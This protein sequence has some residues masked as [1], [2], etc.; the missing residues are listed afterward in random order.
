MAETEQIIDGA[1]A[2]GEVEV[3]LYEHFYEPDVEA[4]RAFYAAIAA[5]DLKGQP[6]WPMIVAP[7][8]CGKT[9]LINPLK[10]MPN[11][12]LIDSITPNTLISGRAPE[13]GKQR[14]KEG[15]L[16]RIGSNGMIFI[17]D[18]STLLEG[19]REK[20]DQVFAQLR[21]VYDGDLRKEFG[22]AG[23]NTEWSG[24]LSVGVAVTPKVD[25][26]TSVFGALGERFIMIRWKRV[27]GVDAALTAMQQD[28]AAKDT[29]MRQAVRTLFD[30]MKHA[31][32]PSIPPPLKLAIAATAELIA[33]G[34][35]AV[36]RERD[37]RIEY[38]PEPE[39]AT[40]LAQQFCQL[41]KGSAR[42]ESREYVDA[43]DLA[44]VHRVAFDT[45]HPHRTA[46]LRALV[47]GDRADAA[48]LA[49]TTLRRVLEDLQMVG[50]TDKGG[51][52][53]EV[54]GWSVLRAC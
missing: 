10:G 6:V 16:E 50:L 15:L 43:A 39:G 8:G 37:D 35:T 14:G 49:P 46:V 24:R 5:H 30:A 44:L 4:A 22:I 41:A 42:L 40:R 17:P 26:Y 20:R 36:E 51:F 31:P 28:H 18:F 3:A 52:T 9:E 38:E 53:T 12:H 33:R 2:W 13:P 27:A 54:R 21:R 11:T 29:A 34:R 32:E 7:P 25:R 45:L 23:L 19:N 47:K 48:K 1:Y